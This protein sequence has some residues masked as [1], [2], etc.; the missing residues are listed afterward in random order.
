MIV[1]TTGACLIAF[2]ASWKL[3]LAMLATVPL[4]LVAGSVF[5]LFLGGGTMGPERGRA[6]QVTF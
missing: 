4:S 6:G 2:D 3:A 5:N 1:A